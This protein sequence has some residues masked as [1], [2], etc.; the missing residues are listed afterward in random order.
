MAEEIE[1]AMQQAPHPMRHNPLF[2]SAFWFIPA[3]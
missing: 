1:G 2:L 3:R